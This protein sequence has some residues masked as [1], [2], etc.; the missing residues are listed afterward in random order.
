MIKERKRTYF[1][2]DMHLKFDK[3]KITLER[4]R[5][6]AD[7]LSTLPEDTKEIV[8]L[9]DIFDFWYEWKYVVPSYHFDLFCLFSKLIGSGIKI[10]YV[11]GN[12]DFMLGRYLKEEV[13]IECI[14]DEIVIKQGNIRIW[15]SHGDGL[16]EPDKGYR[17]MK[18]VL[19]SP[20]CNFLFRTFIHPD[21]AVKIASIASK[22]SRRHRK[23]AKTGINEYLKFAKKKFSEGYDVVITG[24]RHFPQRTVMQEGVFVNTG[25][26]MKHFSYA[27]F[28]GKKISIGKYD[29]K[30]ENTKE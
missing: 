17:F 21:L 7:F 24:H 18:K 19:R 8:L 22:T 26:W 1:V 11:A 29:D 9:G 3:S 30:E 27:V 16:A 20:V 13:G 4:K 6:F 14:E 15:A 23:S 25:D 2:S 5:K 28:D 12:H 10:T